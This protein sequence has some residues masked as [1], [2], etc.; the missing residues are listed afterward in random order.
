[1]HNLQMDSAAYYTKGITIIF[2]AVHCNF[3]LIIR[4]SSEML[5]WSWRIAEEKLMN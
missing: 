5:K 1:M 4:A 3:I 2:I